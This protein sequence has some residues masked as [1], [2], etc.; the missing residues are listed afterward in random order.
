MNQPFQKSLDQ[1]KALAAREKKRLV[2]LLGGFVV[3]TFILV[4]TLRQAFT[5]GP[6]PEAVAISDESVSDEPI[7][8][9]PELDLARLATL[10]RDQAPADRVV[11]ESE[12]ADLVLDS[13]RRYTP[14]HFA[15]LG[16]RELD[17]ALCSELAAAPAAE[18]G[19]PFTARGRIVELRARSG[20]AHE[21]QTLG[22]LELEDGSSVHFLALELPED[23]ESVGGFVRLDGLFLKL[24]ST[25]DELDAGTWNEGPLLVGARVERSFASFGKVETLELQRFDGLEDA[26]L[27]PDPGQE[28]R[29]VTE[30]PSEPRW[31]LMAY[32]R[33]GAGALE[34]DKAP[35]LDQRLLDQI[36][37][38]PEAFRLL[39]VRIPISRLQDGRVS[40]AGENPARME[41][42]MQGWIGNNTWLGAIQ[43]RSPVL[44]PD[45][46]IGEFV[47]GR[48]FFL[49]NFAFESA[50]AGL[51][52][53]PVF[54]LES[55][56]RFVPETS[57]TL[58]NIGMV[59]AGVGALLVLTFLLLARLDRKKAGEFQEELT[60]RRRA[61][62]ERG[63]KG[64]T[65]SASP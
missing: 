62:R 13:A 24:Y 45:F 7:L 34:W 48:G 11:L 39:P 17:Q 44:H 37:A 52:V 14:R 4:T 28:I 55:I 57:A 38:D 6:A 9:V 27:T 2:F 63:T 20:A 15:T 21:P 42:Y 16:T 60:R 31:H 36:Q 53:A 23:A 12:A 56:E 58:G 46:R 40:V 26:D 54:V 59:V 41:R 18:R 32:A 49:H 1:Q 65:G 35:E 29:F 19:K 51:R 43:F 10:V 47:H 50:G 25:E 61:R 5:T 33:D 22:R 64:L 8:A 3:I 30:T